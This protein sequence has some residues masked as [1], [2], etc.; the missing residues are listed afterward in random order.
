MS[1]HII[2]A[3]HPSRPC[4]L[5]GG[6]PH[7]HHISDPIVAVSLGINESQRHGTKKPAEHQR[8]YF[9]NFSPSPPQSNT[10]CSHSAQDKQI[11][12]TRKTDAKKLKNI[13]STPIFRSMAIAFGSACS[14][15]RAT[16][17][18]FRWTSRLPS[19]QF[20]AIQIPFHAENERYEVLLP[21]IC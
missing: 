18:D 12:Q 3:I 2:A 4:R 13:H 6:V 19:V 20:N 14:R 16:Y 9:A 10:V 17:S 11:G 5:S 7:G 15:T 1:I 21:C 8:P